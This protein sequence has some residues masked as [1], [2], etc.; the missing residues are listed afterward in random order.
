[1]L[2]KN[3]IM[4][5]LLAALVS[6]CSTVT[7]RPDGGAKLTTPPTY[8][9]KKDFFIYGLAGEHRVDVKDVCGGSEPTQMQTQQTFED[10]LFTFFTFGIYAPH[11][12]NV[13]CE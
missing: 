3:S 13:W 11:H 2:R 4:L 12:A 8:S 1:M 7:I 9:E 10:G 5:V 6:A